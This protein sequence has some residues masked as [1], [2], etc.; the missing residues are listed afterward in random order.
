MLNPGRTRSGNMKP[1][2]RTPEGFPNRCPVCGHN[3]DID[4]SS[5]PIVDAPCPF[6]GHLLWFDFPSQA[7]AP[8]YR[9][10][11]TLRDRYPNLVETPEKVAFNRGDRITW[12]VVPI[13]SAAIVWAADLSALSA[14]LWLSFT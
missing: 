9:T 13:I 6:C 11:L 14:F 4:P 3:V 2:S 5:Y 10:E 7:P 1:S 8:G 12:V